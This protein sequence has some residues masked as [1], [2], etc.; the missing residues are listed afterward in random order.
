[1]PKLWEVADHKEVKLLSDIIEEKKLKVLVAVDRARGPAPLGY[2]TE[3]SGAE[4][5]YELLEQ[6]ERE[7]LVRRSP[8]SAWSSAG[9]PRFEL[10]PRTKR[11]LRK[12]IADKIVQLIEGGQLVEV[13]G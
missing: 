4:E 2:I 8:P 10:E 5:P 13:R 6:L 7:G 12:L 3:H 1:M 11:I 9:E